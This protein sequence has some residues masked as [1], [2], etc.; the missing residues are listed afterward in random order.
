MSATMNQPDGLGGNGPGPAPGSQTAA[1]Q[2][3]AGQPFGGGQLLGPR[4]GRDAT[5]V[6]ATSA[7]MAG[8]GSG[9]P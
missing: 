8:K 7:T 4:T 5:P 1:A 3:N 2:A 6:P 9:T